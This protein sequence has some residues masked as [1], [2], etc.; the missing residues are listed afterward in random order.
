MI[1]KTTKI[2]RKKHVLIIGKSETERRHFINQLLNIVNYET[3]RFPKAM[4]TIDE[5][6]NFIKK[7]QLYQPW[8]PQK[9]YNSNQILDFHWDWITENNSL[10]VM[11]EF[12]YMEKQWQI[13]LIKE[14]I[15]AIENHKKGEKHIHLIISQDS[16]NEIVSE[17][18]ETIF[19]QENER[20]TKI[21]IMAQNLEI[22][23]LS[24]I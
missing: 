24:E 7:H 6:F 8:Y 5:Y 20:R 4:R 12:Q 21:Q 16:E 1:E 18:S 9:S 11:E 2:L 14:Y 15:N 22:I 23:D 10:I 13:E 3:F 17:I 19:I